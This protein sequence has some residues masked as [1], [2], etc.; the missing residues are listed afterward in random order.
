MVL[1][2]LKLYDG[3]GWDGQNWQIFADVLNKKLLTIFHRIETINVEYCLKDKISPE[4]EY[5]CLFLF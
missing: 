2:F 3:A 1:D 4:E 5:I